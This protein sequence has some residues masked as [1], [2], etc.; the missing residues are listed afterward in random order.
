MIIGI[1]LGIMVVLSVLSI[2][3][4][5]SFMSIDFETRW[6]RAITQGASVKTRFNNFTFSIDEFDGMLVIIT[7]IILLASLVG[8][9]VLATGLSD[10]SVKVVT[11]ATA[12]GGIWAVLSVLSGAMI[13]D[14]SVFGALIYITLTIAYVIGIIQ[15]HVGV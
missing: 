14:I 8:I 13:K 2:I 3:L 1:S 5:G 11:V 4:G 15:K 12:Y 7:V 10:S 9:K 6:V